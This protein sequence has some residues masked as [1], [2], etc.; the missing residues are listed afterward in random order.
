MNKVEVRQVAAEAL[1]KIRDP[2]AVSALLDA[3]HDENSGSLVSC[4]VSKYNINNQLQLFLRLL[5]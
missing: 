5:T 2:A 1:G 4:G 3:L